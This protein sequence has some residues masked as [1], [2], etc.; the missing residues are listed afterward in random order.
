MAKHTDE[1]LV[2]KLKVKS[3]PTFLLFKGGEPKP[4]KYDGASYTY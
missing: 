3:F 1:A 2:K 4:I